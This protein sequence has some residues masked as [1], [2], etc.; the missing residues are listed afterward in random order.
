MDFM[1]AKD[2]NAL[3]RIYHLSNGF[4]QA[5]MIWYTIHPYPTFFSKAAYSSIK[6]QSLNSVFL[7]K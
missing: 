6:K 5:K 3:K 2:T 1:H 7:I 4:K